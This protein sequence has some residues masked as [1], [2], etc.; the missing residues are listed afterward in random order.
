MSWGTFN[1]INLKEKLYTGSLL[2]SS[3]T[4]LQDLSVMII[5]LKEENRVR[6]G[7]K[8]GPPLQ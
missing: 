7:M 5:D 2:N 4:L 1:Y 3:C 8:K 6:K